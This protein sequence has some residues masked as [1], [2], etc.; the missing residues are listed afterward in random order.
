MSTPIFDSLMA[1]SDDTTRALVWAG[2]TPRVD[3]KITAGISQF[4]EQMNR[5]GKAYALVAKVEPDAPCHTSTEVR[6]SGL[7]PK[8]G[9]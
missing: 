1:E 4:I 9:A 5:L 7:L 8:A 2:I 3:V 6:E